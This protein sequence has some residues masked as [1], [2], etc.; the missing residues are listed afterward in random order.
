[1]FIPGI[2]DYTKKLMMQ[3]NDQV[4]MIMRHQERKDN[5]SVSLPWGTVTP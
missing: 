5:G 3:I 1:M 4:P 2:R